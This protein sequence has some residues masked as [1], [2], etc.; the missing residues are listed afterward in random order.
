MADIDPEYALELAAAENEQPV[1]ALTPDAAD[2]ALDVR[3]GVRRPHGRRDDRR[4]LAVEDGVEGAA[5]LRVTVVDQ[6]ARPATTIIKIHQQVACLLR[7]PATVGVACS[8]D[9][10]DSA[11][12]DADEHEHVHTAQQDGVHGEEV[13]GKRRRGVLAQERAPVQPVPL[14]CRRNPGR[15]EDVA[16]QGGRHIDPEH[17]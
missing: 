6:E 3:V 13:T 1:Q 4:P 10:L 11:A 15:S 8:S 5:E 17:A 9:V 12:A 7:H 14:G 2:P 16:H